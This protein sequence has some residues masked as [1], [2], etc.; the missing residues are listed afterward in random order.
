M[1]KKGRVIL[2]TN[3]RGNEIKSSHRD[4]RYMIKVPV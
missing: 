3:V 2:Q 4:T 1:D